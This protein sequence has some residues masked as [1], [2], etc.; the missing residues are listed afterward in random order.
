MNTAENEIKKGQCLYCGNNPTPHTATYISE[1][2]LVLVS[3]FGKFINVFNRPL[4]Y[5]VFH[6]T[7]ISGW[8]RFLELLHLIHF[9]NDS[10]TACS[11]RSGVIWAEAIR[12]GITME[13]M[14]ISDKPVEQYRAYLG[15]RW[16]YFGS[17]PIPPSADR[18][19][20]L[21]MD[22]KVALKKYLKE[23]GV[24][25]PQGGGASTRAQA[26]EI[27]NAVLK[28]VI[29]KPEN[30][31]RGRHTLTNLST[32]EDL[33]HGF[34]VASQLCYRVVVEEHLKGSVYRG[35]YVGGEIVGVLRGDPPRITGDG[36]S[37]IE[38]LIEK[39]NREKHEGVKD[40]VVSEVIREFLARQGYTT[41]SIVEKGKTIDIIEKIGLSYGGDAVE[42]FPLAHPK[43]LDALKKAGD[44]L[45]VPVIG[46]DFISEDITKDP[47]TVRWGIIEANS[48]PFIDLHHFP[49]EGAPINVAG[50]VWDLWSLYSYSK[51]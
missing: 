30:G 40:V 47:D 44:V 35:T 45:G 12:R 46:F 33:H 29:V 51:K 37:T 13:Q 36:V 16:H 27:F 42:E 38:Q 7:L 3:P 19:A 48:V 25:V 1:S 8:V 28:P 32:I 26:E 21:W 34:K 17:I 41:M 2:I 11:Q 39:K 43:L 18:R 10:S 24:R 31:S 50:K 20:Y 15:G 6:H 9:T 49:R 5:K 22:S 14:V 23:H 4:L